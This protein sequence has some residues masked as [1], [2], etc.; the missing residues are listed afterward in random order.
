MR[1]GGGA[2]LRLWS[3]WNYEGWIRDRDAGLVW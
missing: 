1:V 2:R 3:R